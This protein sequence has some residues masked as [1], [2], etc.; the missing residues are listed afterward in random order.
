MDLYGACILPKRL[1]KD[2]KSFSTLF[3]MLQRIID[4]NGHIFDI[5]VNLT[6]EVLGN[7]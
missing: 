1:W 6:N 4:D 7:L 2:N 5:T 3:N